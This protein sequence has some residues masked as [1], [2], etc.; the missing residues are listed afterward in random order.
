MLRLAI[1]SLADRRRR[2][3]GTGVAIVV[4]VAFL[5]GTLVLG[6]T[7]SR[8]FAR[9]FTDVSAGTDVVVRNATAVDPGAVIDARGP[10]P[11]G[12]VDTVAR[13]PGVARA[14][15]QIVGYGSLLGADGRPIGGNG[16]PRQAGSWIDDAK[17]NPYRLVEGRA[18][19]TDDEV[20]INRGAARS[21][22]LHLGDRTVVQTPDPV[23]VSIVGIATFGST[24]GFDRRRGRRSRSRVPNG[25]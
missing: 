9:L 10:I 24:D 3:V 11:A 6:D 2:L 8:N 23:T 22:G 17:L 19:R 20:V 5:T 7:L 12:V 16:P 25:T 21:G 15:G 1:A 18:P 14:E 13:V 4:G